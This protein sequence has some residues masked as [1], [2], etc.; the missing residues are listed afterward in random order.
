MATYELLRGIHCDKSAKLV[1]RVHRDDPRAIVEGTDGMGEQEIPAD[2]TYMP[3]DRFSTPKDMSR[4]NDPSNPRFK[5]VDDTEEPAPE[6]PVPD[7]QSKTK[8]KTKS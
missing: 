1:S 3:G 6:T 2:G 8:V 4:H 5:K 7:P